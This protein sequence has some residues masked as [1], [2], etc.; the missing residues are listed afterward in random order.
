MLYPPS[1]FFITVREKPVPG[2]G[3]TDGGFD[4]SHKIL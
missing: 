3:M 2:F 4:F 1:T